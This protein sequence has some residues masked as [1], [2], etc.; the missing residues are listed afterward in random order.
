[1]TSSLGTFDLIGIRYTLGRSVLSI[2]MP[3]R[4]QSLVQTS[5]FRSIFAPEYA[6]YTT[7]TLFCTASASFGMML[8]FYGDPVHVSIK[9]VDAMCRVIF[10]LCG[11]YT[12]NPQRTFSRTLYE[13]VGGYYMTR[14]PLPINN[15]NK[16]SVG[17]VEKDEIFIPSYIDGDNYGIKLRIYAVHREESDSS[18]QPLFM[19][20]H[21]GGFVISHVDSLEYDTVCVDLAKTGYVV[22]SVEYRLAPDH[23][24]PSAI[25]DAY[26]A[27]LWCHS[28][29]P[30]TDIGSPH[31]VSACSSGGNHR[32]LRHAD[33]GKLVVGGD[34][35]GGN[36]AAILSH[37]CRNKINTRLQPAMPTLNYPMSTV[38]YIHKLLLV[39]PSC[40]CRDSFWSGPYY[41]EHGHILSGKVIDFFSEMYKPVNMAMEDWLADVRVSP[42]LNTD[43][44]GLPPTVLVTAEKDQLVDEC[45]EYYRRLVEAGVECSHVHMRNTVHGFWGM[46]FLAEHQSAFKQAME[47][48]AL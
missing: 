13:L 5:L 38:L 16:V 20:L 4:L 1:M 22:V 9:V 29:N 6:L 8:R 25:D 47:L 41:R 15:N 12:S 18:T 34:S 17:T 7:T 19:Y 2:S 37:C 24:W 21:G 36:C 43:F 11:A 27:L 32:L 10:P 23:V 48:L 26:S 45:V 14:V 35:A 31:A 30:T 33:V 39:Y 44:A 40:G 3:N 46:F 42:L 28:L